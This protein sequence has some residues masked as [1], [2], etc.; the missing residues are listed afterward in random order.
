MSEE[1]DFSDDP[2]SSTPDS[3]AA[4]SATSV[5]G[6]EDRSSAPS[7]E[8]LGRGPFDAEADDP[9]SGG[10]SPGGPSR[11][12][13]ARMAW[14]LT[15]MWVEEHQTPAMLGAFAVGVFAGAYLRD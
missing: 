1:S 10:A 3:S 15:R 14:D 9:F 8:S 6:T 7:S 4:G 12:D 5:G 13:Q 11:R 2:S